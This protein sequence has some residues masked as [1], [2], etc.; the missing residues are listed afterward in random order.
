MSLWVVLVSVMATVVVMAFLISASLKTGLGRHRENLNVTAKTSLESIFIFV[1]G[2]R[3]FRASLIA[4]IVIPAGVWLLFDNPLLAAASAGIV[5]VAPKTVLKRLQSRRLELFER[6]LPDALLMISGSM[7]A[8]ASLA[9][10]MESMSKESK[11]PLSQEFALMLAEQRLGVDFEAALSNMEKRLP[12]PDFV[13]LVAAMR[14]TREVGGNFA[15]ILESL[16]HTLRRKHEMEGKIKALTAQGRMQ[17]IVMAAL[18][19]FL[20]LILTYMEPEAMNPLY[21]TLMGWG[22]LAVVFVM[23]TLGYLGIR[24]IVNIDV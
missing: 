24:K 9:V 11:P 10:A 6:Q 17:G 14:I 8:G 4:V 12:V 19:L 18:P 1:D 16:S 2:D 3:L 21:N 15:E 20:M 23:I 5:L 22:T 7:R 13:L